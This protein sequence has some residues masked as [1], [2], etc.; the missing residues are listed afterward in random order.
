M[1]RRGA[2]GQSAGQLVWQAQGDLLG[3]M[4]DQR[5]P[6]ATNEIDGP[7]WQPTKSRITDAPIELP[8]LIAAHANKNE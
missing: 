8:S 1:A 7:M 2:G 4:M 6:V 3:G 5:S